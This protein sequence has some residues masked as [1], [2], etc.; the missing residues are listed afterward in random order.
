MV[1]LMP[2]FD[3]GDS[4]SSSS[5]AQPTANGSGAQKV[6]VSWVEG[7]QQR[8][9]LLLIQATAEAGR[10]SSQD[11]CLRLEPATDPAN[12]ERSKSISKHHFF[13]RYLGNTVQFIDVGSAC[14]SSMDGKPVQ[15]NTPV[16]VDQKAALCVAEVLD[17]EVEP[18]LRADAPAEDNGLFQDAAAHASDPA[19]LQERLV[20]ADKPGRIAFLRISRKNNLPNQQ[21]ILLFHAGWIGSG[22]DSLLRIPVSELTPR[23]KRALDLGV[24]AVDEPARILVRDGAIWIERTGADDVVMGDQ[25]LDM[26]QST[27]LEA[28]PLMIGKTTFTLTMG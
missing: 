26:G 8:T 7:S 4:D 12:Y 2:R 22:D 17:L 14:G 21:Y 9:A 10:L 25:H 27:A 19:W 13:L 16:A 1:V 28:G 23:R 20:G 24:S 5:A 6:A 15:A 18:V 11:L 3:L